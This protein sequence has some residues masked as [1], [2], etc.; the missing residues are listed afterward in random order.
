MHVSKFEI[1]TLMALGIGT[2]KLSPK[3]KEEKKKKQIPGPTQPPD[4]G[5]W[6]RKLE[7]EKRGSTRLAHS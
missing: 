4:L 7:Q 2:Y 1:L 5:H 3:L 6:K